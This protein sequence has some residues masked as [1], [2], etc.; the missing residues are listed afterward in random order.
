MTTEA[1]FTLPDA[2]EPA[3]A[4]PELE[5][6]YL[7]SGE[8][9][10][11][12]VQHLIEF[13]RK[14][15]SSALM[16]SVGGHLQDFEDAAWAMYNALDVDTAVGH[17]LDL[18][19]AIVGERR[20]GREDDDYRGAVRARILVNLSNGRLEDMLRV[21]LAMLPDAT[22]I[23]AEYYPAALRFDIY[24][25]FTGT[26]PATVARML[27]QAKPAGVRLDVVVVDQDSTM[28]W[29]SPEG[30]DLVNGWGADWA[31]LV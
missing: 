8:H 14:P 6:Q 2:P 19:G 16:R 3:P 23:D 29:S 7:Y 5:G 18:L 26:Q 9:A 22:V 28:I 11:Q 31:R 21:L 30:A 27:R 24:D 15:R 17:W 13:F 12:M 10:E 20:D 25:A 1:I 4:A